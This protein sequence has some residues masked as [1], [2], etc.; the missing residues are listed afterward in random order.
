MQKKAAIVFCFIFVGLTQGCTPVKSQHGNLL[1]DYQIETI[2]A[3]EHSRSDVL[4][5]LGSPT[6]QSAFNP[7]I[8]YYLGQEMEKRGILDEKVTEERIVRV[9]F[10]QQGIVET[11]ELLDEERQNIPFAR[12]KTPT[13]GNDLTVAQQL[14]GNLGRFNA[15]QQESQ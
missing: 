2:Q 14:L 1:Q 12:G 6:T 5:L 4:R 3:G 15:P 8:W 10:N 9:T 13:H 7:D 11:T